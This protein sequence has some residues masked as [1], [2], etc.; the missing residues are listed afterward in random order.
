[1]LD[2][3][4]DISPVLQDSESEQY[5]LSSAATKQK[6]ADDP[7][8]SIAADGRWPPP[9]RPLVFFY[10]PMVWSI[11]EIFTSPRI[12]TMLWKSWFR[13]IDRIWIQYSIR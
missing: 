7:A 13:K 9:N 10:A 4:T 1:M 12:E 2:E 3:S 8:V 11:I 5:P 6:S